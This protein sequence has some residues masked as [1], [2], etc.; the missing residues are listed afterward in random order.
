MDIPSSIIQSYSK[1]W[2]KVNWRSVI[3]P[4]SSHTAGPC[5]IGQ[6]AANLYSGKFTAAHITLLSSF[7]E[8]GK[9]HM[10][11]LALIGGLLSMRPDDSRLCDSAVLAEEAGIDI[12][13][14]FD[15]NP[16]NN[17][18][19]NEPNVA[20]VELSNRGQTLKVIGVSIGGGA[21]VLTQINDEK[22]VISSGYANTLVLFRDKASSIPYNIGLLPLSKQLNGVDVA[23]GQG[24]I[25]LASTQQFDSNLIHAVSAIKGVERAV[26]LSA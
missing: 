18:L 11:D 5:L 26:L 20:V 9:G 10:T 24:I 7:A 15:S 25:T 6:H 23:I 19:P 22:V 4:S 16:L 3:G 8:T 14:T 21:I 13:V 2:P 12:R 17:P 1:R